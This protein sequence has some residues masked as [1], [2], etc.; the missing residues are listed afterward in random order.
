MRVVEGKVSQ[1]NAAFIQEQLSFI[2]PD[3]TARQVDFVSSRTCS[4]GHLQDQQV[5][6]VGVC[7]VCGAFTCSAPGCSFTCGRCGKAVCRGHARVYGE[8]ESYCSHC[9]RV[10]WLRELVL[11][12]RS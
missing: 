9:A 11:G 1:D 2:E 12:R 7:E 3:M 6:L 5:R 10:V 4:F 8:T